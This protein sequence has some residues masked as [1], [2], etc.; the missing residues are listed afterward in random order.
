MRTRLLFLVLMG[1]TLGAANAQQVP[2]SDVDLIAVL[3]LARDASP[4]LSIERQAIALAHANRITAG[5]YPNPTVSVG[6]FRKS[7]TRSTLFDGSRQDQGTVEFPLLIAGQRAARIERAE[8]EIEAARARVA[9]GASSLGGEAGSAYVALLAAQDKLASF[10]I[11][12]E[13]L[14]RL[15]NIVA[16]RQEGGVA[17]RYDVTRLDIEVSGFRVK[18]NEAEAD[19]VDQAGIFAALLGLPNWRPKA[20]G[21][22]TPLK[23][24]ADTDLDRRER[25]RGSPAVVAAMHDERVAQSGVEVARRERWP[26]LSVSAGRSWTTEPYGAANLIGLSVEIPLFDTRRGPLAKAEAD[27]IT[28]G[29]RRDLAL[30]EVAANLDRY[31]NIMVAR[32]AALQRFEQDTSA[33]LP[34]I[35]Q[36]AEDAYRLGRISIFE[37][38]DTTRS[39]HEL[40]Q[41]RI[42]LAAALLDAQLRYL[43]ITGDLERRVGLAPGAPARP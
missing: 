9:S 40:A 26:A 34:A 29:L 23:L 39:R 24:E 11:S 14:L 37:L 28:S 2:P 7:G 15:R 8:R 21:T 16:G 25:A 5:V 10:A 4:R 42:E 30:A 27:V 41:R 19:V 18:V 22:L 38:L 35:K 43:A 20:S 6:Q 32:Q 13:E 3:R 1:G 31:A 36:M 12:Q 33:H 17:S